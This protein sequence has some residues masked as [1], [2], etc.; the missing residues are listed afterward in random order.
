MRVYVCTC[1]YIYVC[2]HVNM[3]DSSCGYCILI[4]HVMVCVCLV[5]IHTGG[6]GGE[7]GGGGTHLA[8]KS[9][10]LLSKERETSQKGR[11]M[12]NG[13]EQARGIIISLSLSRSLPLFR[14]FALSLAPSAAFLSPPSPSPAPRVTLG[15][16][17]RVYRRSKNRK[18]SKRR[19]PCL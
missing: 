10:I 18:G 19:L 16:Q 5:G 11:S 9:S 14:S 4:L 8:I 2:V 1:V 15:V 6:G 3:Y 7:G 13:V 12:D 17:C